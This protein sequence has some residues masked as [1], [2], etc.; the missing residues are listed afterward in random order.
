MHATCHWS[1]ADAAVCH[2]LHLPVA[3]SDGH[4][5]V[6]SEQSGATSALVRLSLICLNVHPCSKLC[7]LQVSHAVHCVATRGAREWNV[8]ETLQGSDVWQQLLARTV[9]VITEFEVF[10]HNRAPH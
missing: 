8:R 3:L 7:L 6:L 5:S 4:R 2:S 9:A 10:S 1:D